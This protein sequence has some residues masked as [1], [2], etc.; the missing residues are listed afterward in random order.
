MTSVLAPVATFA[1][2]AAVTVISKRTSLISAQAF[3]SLTLVT[4]VANPILFLVQG[5]PY[6][7]SGIGC[8]GRIEKYLISTEGRQR[9]T[10]AQTHK[11][12]G[13]S[14]SLNFGL[15]SKNNSAIQLIDVK[16]EQAKNSTSD[17]DMIV[18]QNGN[19]GWRSEGDLVLKDL[20][21][22]VREGSLNMIV[23]VIGCG[24]STLL[25]ALLGE[26]PRSTGHRLLHRSSIAYCDQSPW[27]TNATVQNTII[28]MSTLDPAWYETVLHACSLNIDLEKLPKGDQ[29]QVGSKGVT[30]SGGQKQRIVCH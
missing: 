2:Y 22:R 12:E 21:F 14:Q 29:S 9:R 17:V 3:T 11:T 28:G 1:L 10:L 4:L 24:K 20:N 15:N 18:V 25:R 19:F 8:L 27:L 7:A 16:Q 26:L 5:V 13:F 23:G 30:L 6:I